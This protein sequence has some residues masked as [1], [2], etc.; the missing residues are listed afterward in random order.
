MTATKTAKTAKTA[1]PA[2][3]K[4]AT[5]SPKTTAKKTTAKKTTAK[6]TTAKKTTAKKTAAKKTTAK[7]TAAKKTA[8]K[9][10]AAKKTAA[11]KTAT[12][13]TATK[14]MA[15]ASAAR[16]ARLY[17][18]SFASIYALYVQKI[19]RKGRS[20]EEL[21]E[22][23]GW[24][25][26]YRGASLKRAL[27]D[28]RDLQAFFAGATLHP[29]ASLITGLICGVRIE[30]LEDPLMKQIRWLDKLVDELALGRPMA[31]ILRASD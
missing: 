7:K 27:D 25:T 23:I 30:D 21:D 22:V 10:T 9:K 28:K 18:Y 14:K 24:L 8:A 26:G 12:K 16:N 17:A 29:N 11:K 4:E 20:R 15:S 6:K 3:K 19:E 1:K 5:S 2:K 13:K 31:R